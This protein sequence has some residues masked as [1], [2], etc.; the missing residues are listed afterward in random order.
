MHTTNESP[1]MTDQ[2]LSE[3]QDGIRR[4]FDI[5]YTC[6]LCGQEHHAETYVFHTTDSLDEL[7][8]HARAAMRQDE[9]GLPLLARHMIFVHTD[10]GDYTKLRQEADLHGPKG[11]LRLLSTTMTA[12]SEFSCDECARRF[13]TAGE[14][15]TH[16]GIDPDTAQRNEQPQ[17]R[18]NVD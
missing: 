4:L 2:E 15:W 11:P 18:S 12:E 16:M 3:G 9:I 7:H 10:R 1:F 6:P 14:M 13:P 8:A 5:A 17:C